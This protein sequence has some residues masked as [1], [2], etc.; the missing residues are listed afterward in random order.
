MNYNIQQRNV[1]THTTKRGVSI[2]VVALV[3]AMA[4]FQYFSEQI[5]NLLLTVSWYWLIQKSFSPVCENVHLCFLTELKSIHPKLDW[6]LYIYPRPKW[7][8]EHAL[9]WIGTRFTVYFWH[10]PS[11]SKNTPYWLKYVDTWSCCCWTLRFN[12]IKSI[13]YFLSFS[14]NYV[15]FKYA[16]HAGYINARKWL[17]I[18]QDPSTPSNTIIGNFKSLIHLNVMLKCGR[19]PE[20]PHRHRENIIHIEWTFQPGMYCCEVKGLAT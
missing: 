11:L 15:F 7:F 4:A 5:V 9:Q 10:V 17:L 13:Y 8:S 6:L 14:L 1:L 12:S 20:H 18:T 2:I 19:I 16:L 3:L